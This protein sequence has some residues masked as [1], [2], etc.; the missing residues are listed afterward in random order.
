M[1]LL[2]GTVAAEGK[3]GDGVLALC[4]P[5]LSPPGEWGEAAEEKEAMKKKKMVCVSSH[6]AATILFSRPKSHEG[7]CGITRDAILQR[8]GGGGGRLG[9]RECVC[10]C[11]Q[12]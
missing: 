4:W 3:G 11:V 7:D 2:P 10:V 8:E 1:V 6:C 5:V 9:Q 12:A